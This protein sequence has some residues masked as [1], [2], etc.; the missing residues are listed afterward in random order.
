MAKQSKYGTLYLIATPIDEQNPLDTTALNLLKSAIEK[1][2]QSL[3]LIEDLKPCR[4][5][6]I[7]FGLDREIIEDFILFNEHTQVEI[8]NEIITKIQS[9]K[10][11]YLMSDGG[12]PAFCDPGQKLVKRCHELGI[13]VTCTPH[14]NSIS[15]AVALSG[16][17]CAN[18]TFAGFPPRRPEERKEFLKNLTKVN[19]PKVLMDTPYR[20]TRLL[21]ESVEVFGD[22]LAFVGMELNGEDEE[23]K[24]G[25]LSKLLKDISGLKKEF[26]LIIK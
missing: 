4:R 1:R 12:L 23:L 21:E 2:E 15:L 6:W 19:M 20:L 9:G 14:S 11:A 5:R 3:F 16:I 25:K 24:Y 8:E 13:R 26:I 10:N 17:D 22:R 7:R 18:F